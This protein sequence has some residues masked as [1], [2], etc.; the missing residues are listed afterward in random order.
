MSP[1]SNTTR[2]SLFI[3]AD[4]ISGREVSLPSNNK[5]VS[6]RYGFILD[7]W[8]FG[9][10]GKCRRFLH[11]DFFKVHLEPGVLV[12]V[13]GPSMVQINLSENYSSL[14]ETFDKELF[15]ESLVWPNLGLHPG[16]LANTLTIMPIFIL[17]GKVWNRTFLC[18]NWTVWNISMTQPGI[19][20]RSTGPLANIL[21]IRRANYL[22]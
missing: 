8:W 18:F 12:P 6:S 11:C 5:N 17:N 22:Y 4:S 1:N 21:T 2:S 3:L 7:I 15:F 9:R 20:L 19:E 10:F 14:T 13:R 16:L